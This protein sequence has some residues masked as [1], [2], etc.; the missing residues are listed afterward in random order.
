MIIL[1]RYILI[2]YLRYSGRSSNNVH[3]LC[4]SVL[5]RAADNDTPMEMSLKSYRIVLFFFFF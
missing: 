5:R 3:I 2:V 4:K 1:Q